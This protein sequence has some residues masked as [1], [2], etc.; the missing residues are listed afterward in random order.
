[1]RHPHALT[2][3]LL[4]AP[5]LGGAAEDVPE[6]LLPHSTQVYL[7]WDGVDAHKQAYDKTSLGQMMKGDTGAFIEGVFDKLQTSAA[8]LMTVDTLRRGL[9]PKALK[10]MQAD[11]K[12]AAKLF[13][14]LGKQGFL[15]AAE[16]RQQEPPQGDLYLILPGMGTDADPL[17]GSLRLAIELA[18]VEI[19]EE[20][21][22]DRS[23]AS[24][25]LG[26]VNLAWWVEGQ[27]AVVALSTD[28]PAA[29]VKKMAARANQALT[30]KPLFQRITSFKKFETYARAFVDVSA[31][32]KM[33]AKRG[34]E[35]AKLLDDLGV[36]GLRSVALYSGY[37]GR[38]ERGLI[39]WD[40]PGTRKGLL[41][42]LSGKPFKLGDVPSLPSDVVS[43]STTNF[44]AAAL[45]DAAYKAAE[46]IVG[47]FSPDDLP[48]VKEIAK[49]V[50]DLLGIDL[51]KDL[52]GA[53]GDRFATYTSPADG[54]LSLGQTVLFK[55]K[56]ADK[57]ES[58]LEQLIKN[59]GTASGKQVRI[60]KR[61]YRGVGI[62]EV[63][64]DQQGFLFVPT[65][66][67]H[68][69]WLV[70]GIYPQAVQAFVQRSK[71]EL[72][73][74]KP[75][76]QVRESLDKLPQ[77]FV[78]IGYSDPRPM[79]KLLMSLAPLIAGAVSSFNPSLTIEVGSLPATQEV[80]K[81]LFPNL[82]VISDDGKTL[83]QDSLDS[84]ALPFV[85]TGLFDA[86]LIAAI[87]AAFGIADGQFG[88]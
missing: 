21:I 54:P 24:M 15:L 17:F 51:R 44:D 88:F 35:M 20:K 4:L 78:S 1:M 82:A 56:Y 19:K 5:G 69:N 25:E 63:H 71:G 64:V 9:D 26:P 81:H 38:A 76:V 87:G 60:K 57:L 12:A 10:K 31:L 6:R 83:R 48:R 59:L 75:S 58:T 68:K 52:L 53:L 80:T 7:R 45:Y 61:D 18:Q 85:N 27:H 33:G 49:Q 70:I 22:A 79:T 14:R 37:D 66:A 67:I 28:K 41:K 30:S 77:E 23:V 40:M 65:Y 84:L 72:P 2:F 43:W 62:R 42:L 3:V 32:A 16:L 34:D 29:L 74:W 46:Q 86:L 47:L 13:P 11:A 73:S 55:V 8:A 50:N 39:E 36:M